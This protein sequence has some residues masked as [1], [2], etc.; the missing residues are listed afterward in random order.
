LKRTPTHAQGV[1]PERWLESDWPFAG[2]E[3]VPRA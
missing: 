3:Y 1:I 2:V